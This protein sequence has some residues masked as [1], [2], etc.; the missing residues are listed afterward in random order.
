MDEDSF[1]ADLLGGA[2]DG[3]SAAAGTAVPAASMRHAVGIVVVV[4]VV[5]VEEVVDD[6]ELDEVVVVV[7][8]SAAAS[9]SLPVR[10]S[11]NNATASRTMTVTSTV[12][13]GR[14]FMP[15]ILRRGSPQI[16]SAMASN[17]GER[18]NPVGITPAFG[19]QFVVGT[20]E[21]NEGVNAQCVAFGRRQRLDCGVK[22]SAKRRN[23]A[24]VHSGGDER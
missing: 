13:I 21:R 7:S 4:V 16:W 10:V 12:M 24:G 9:P 3:W 2:G 15:P 14:G 18:R 20:V 17:L 8:T 6:V 11:T 5:E 19:D 22:R 1:N 23:V